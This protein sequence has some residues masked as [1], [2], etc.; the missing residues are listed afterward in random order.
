LHYLNP[1]IT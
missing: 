1:N